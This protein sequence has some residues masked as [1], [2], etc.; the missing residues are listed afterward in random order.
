VTTSGKDRRPRTKPGTD[1]S[2]LGPV[3]TGE[4]RP[5]VHDVPFDQEG[6]RA[7]YSD[8]PPEVPQDSP[9][10]FGA[11]I[12]NCGRCEARSVLT[13]AQALQHVVPSFHLPFIKRENGSW[14][15][16]PSCHHRTWV[17]IEI[18]LL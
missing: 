8:S 18:Q 1:F 10:S 3:A 14:M 7:L 17:S 6:K 13:P 4:S 12:V 11:V 5:T 2:R 16:C 15:R 9:A